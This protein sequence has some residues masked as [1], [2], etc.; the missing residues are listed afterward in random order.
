MIT[1]QAESLELDNQNWWR[2]ENLHLFEMHLLSLTF[3]TSDLIIELLSLVEFLKAVI[4]RRVIGLVDL[5][6]RLFTSR[7]MLNHLVC[8]VVVVMG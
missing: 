6:I 5:I 1:K 3:L 7:S 2:D 4:Q 8:C